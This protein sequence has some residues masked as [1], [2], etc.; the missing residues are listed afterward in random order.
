[1]LTV[2]SHPSHVSKKLS[3]IRKLVSLPFKVLHFL[4]HQVTFHQLITLITY[5]QSYPS[6]CYNTSTLNNH[7]IFNLSFQT[8]P[9]SNK[10]AIDLYLTDINSSSTTASPRISFSYDLSQSDTV[11]VEEL[12]RS[13]SSSSNSS[14]VQ[15]FNFCVHE[16][17]YA[18]SSMADELFLDGKILPSQ[19]IKSKANPYKRTQSSPSSRREDEKLHP[20]ST[21]QVKF[22]YFTFYK[23]IMYN[24]VR[25]MISMYD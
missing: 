18:N 16:N 11:P 21:P 4:H 9:T 20:R 13:F 22:W 6:F 2:D 17:H 14:N 10:M 3:H 5:I 24:V 12:L 8:L 23:V 7:Y 19:V 15:E 25:K 1:M